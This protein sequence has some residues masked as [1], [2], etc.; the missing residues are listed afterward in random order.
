MPHLKGADKKRRAVLQ[1][2]SQ[3]TGEVFILEPPQLPTGT[4]VH[5]DVE[6][7]PLAAVRHDSG[8][9]RDA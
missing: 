8:G 6:T 4:W 3:L 1:A 7:N 2:R 5:F 9:L